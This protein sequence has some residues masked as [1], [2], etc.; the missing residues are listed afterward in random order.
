M[1]IIEKKGWADD[2]QQPLYLYFDVFFFLSE[3][4]PQQSIPPWKLEMLLEMLITWNTPRL[5]QLVFLFGKF[6]K[7]SLVMGLKSSH[8]DEAQQKKHKNDPSGFHQPKNINKDCPSRE[9]SGDQTGSVFNAYLPVSSV[10]SLF[11]WQRHL[12]AI[13]EERQHEGWHVIFQDLAI[14]ALPHPSRRRKR[15]IQGVTQQGG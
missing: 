13:F 14:T 6:I 2:L 12:Q 4:P 8:A 1:N 9:E 15:V 7:E 11:P 5:K 10:G 3:V